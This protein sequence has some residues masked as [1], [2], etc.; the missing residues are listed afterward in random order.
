MAFRGD[1]KDL[2]PA[3]RRLKQHHIEAFDAAI[4]SPPYVTAMPYLDTQRLSLS[5]LELLSSRQLRGGEH[6]LIG[7]REIPDRNRLSLEGR[8]GRMLPGFP[9]NRS[10]FAGSYFGWQTMHHTGS[11]AETYEH[12]VQIPYRH[13]QHVLGRPF[14]DPSKG[15]IRSGRRMQHHRISERRRD[16]HRYPSAFWQRWRNRPAGK[17][18]KHTISTLT[19]ATTSTHRTRS[20]R[21]CCSC[22]AGQRD[23]VRKMTG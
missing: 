6:Q 3:A 8:F 9:K 16:T 13:G 15:P 1:S 11:G 22:F 23:K 18:R 14:A 12:G 20:A 17:S 19:I 5:L 21:K 7:S 10:S 2:A 4:T